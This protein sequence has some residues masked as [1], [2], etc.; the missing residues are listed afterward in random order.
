MSNIF[1]KKIN[2]NDLENFNKVRCELYDKILY[3]IETNN[4]TLNNVLVKE[5]NAINDIIEFYYE[6]NCYVYNLEYN[7]NIQ[8]NNSINDISP[9]SIV[10]IT[11]VN[12][13]N[14]NIKNF[15][16]PKNYIEINNNII[17]EQQDLRKQLEW[18]K[19][20]K[21]SSFIDKLKNNNKKKIIKKIEID[22]ENLSTN[23]SNSLNSIDDEINH[24]IELFKYSFI[25][26]SSIN[27]FLKGGFVIGFKIIQLITEN[28]LNNQITLNPKQIIIDT[29]EFVR[30][31]D[32][33]VCINSLDN[34]QYQY[35]LNQ[36]LSNE[37]ILK[38]FRK[39]GQVVIVLRDKNN[40][41]TLSN[42]S[43]SFIEMS[44]KN[45]ET[46]HDTSHLID[47][48]IPLTSMMVQ[49]H[50]SN[51]ELVFSI[52][53]SYY[54]LQQ[55]GIELED[56]FYYSLVQKIN[57]L[58]IQIYKTTPQGL[59]DVLECYYSSG[60]TKLGK[61]IIEQIENTSNQIMSNSDKINDNH[62]TN[63][64]S[65]KQ[66]LASSI[67]Q[68]DRLFIRLVGKNIPKSARCQRVL[69]KYSIPI[70]NINW[71]L[72]KDILN[73]IIITFLT[74]LSKLYIDWEKIINCT[75]CSTSSINKH[76]IDSK[77]HLMD[78]TIF[79]GCN[80]GRLIGEIDKISNSNDLNKMIGVYDLLKIIFGKNQSQMIINN[81]NPKDQSNILR[82]QKSYF[83]L[84]DKIILLYITHK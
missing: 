84:V 14:N 32:I 36:F 16:I 29:M 35:M 25:N 83:N 22:K 51:I 12:L 53:K 74:N 7:I 37:I 73:K 46:P 66:F 9:N 38:Y 58:S 81:F 23:S 69:E 62:I 52:I 67:I 50:N 43:E 39:E 56:E 28:L 61:E 6:L 68:P 42:Q 65:I 18:I 78:K 55:Y 57:L 40:L 3:N 4:H 41:K 13:S 15:N 20:I 63:S 64:E 21:I 75:D 30:D 33:T 24:Y 5:I 79:C 70:S 1:I 59:F 34:N 49:I 76:I 8:F 2:N 77:I 71:L 54:M 17:I 10:K 48:E 80:L 44:I 26:Y 82:V 45:C 72:D 31:F 47:L 11:L 19:S 27:F 60:N